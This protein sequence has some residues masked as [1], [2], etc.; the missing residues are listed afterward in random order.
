M[1]RRA[2]TAQQSRGAQHQGSRAYGGDVARPCRL[3]AH[4][5]KRFLI[6]QQR[7]HARAARYAD[8]VELR[9][10]G[11]GRGRQYLHAAAGLDG[12]QRLPD[13]MDFR[14]RELGEDLVRTGHIE[15]GEIREK[16]KARC[17]I[18]W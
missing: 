1:R 10:F 5:G 15:L 9:A 14:L 3:A 12:L 13:E 2:L 11:E 7:V 18:A 8:E 4:E 16:K 6:V 17:G